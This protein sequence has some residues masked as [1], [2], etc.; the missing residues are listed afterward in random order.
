LVVRD[1]YNSGSDSTI[2]PTS[3]TLK[4]FNV[5]EIEDT[6]CWSLSIYFIVFNSKER[7]KGKKKNLFSL[8]LS[9]NW[10]R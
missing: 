7:K 6:C 3:L 2:G 1:F 5:S 8:F 10:C 9:Y 4:F